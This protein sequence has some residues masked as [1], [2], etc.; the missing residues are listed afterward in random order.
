MFGAKLKEKFTQDP[1]DSQID[2]FTIKFNYYHPLDFPVNQNNILSLFD[3]LINELKLINKDLNNKHLSKV[4]DYLTKGKKGFTNRKLD[5]VREQLLNAVTSIFEARRQ[6]PQDEDKKLEYSLI[7]LENLYAQSLKNKKN[8]TSKLKLENE[9][10]KLKNSLPQVEQ[11]LL[12][13]ENKGKN[14][15]LKAK[16]ILLIK[17]KLDKAEKN[18]SEGNLYYTEILTR[19]SFYLKREIFTN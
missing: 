12:S 14:I 4:I 19:S 6:L 11:H 1:P 2:L 13:E 15:V 8:K 17:E 3:L 10:K 16:I 7:K 5:T 9:L 18:L